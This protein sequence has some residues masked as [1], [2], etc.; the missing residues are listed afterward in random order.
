M[1]KRRRREK[2]GNEKEK[3]IYI[4][5]KVHQQVTISLM[6]SGIGDCMKKM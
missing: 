2:K 5:A 1:R 3:D 6:K 4:D